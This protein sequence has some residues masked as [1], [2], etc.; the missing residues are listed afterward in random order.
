MQHLD[1]KPCRTDRQYALLSACAP[2]TL[3]LQPWSRRPSKTLFGRVAADVQLAATRSVSRGCSLIWDRGNSHPA[4]AAQAKQP[5]RALSGRPPNDPLVAERPREERE[6]CVLWVSVL[7]CKQRCRSRRW[8]TSTTSACE[9][10]VLRMM[11]SSQ[12]RG[13]GHAQVEGL[14]LQSASSSV[15]CT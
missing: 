9:A 12:T 6:S 8:R 2:G 7:Q 5:V 14:L 1:A 11:R 4:A 15:K 3:A 13:E 10:H